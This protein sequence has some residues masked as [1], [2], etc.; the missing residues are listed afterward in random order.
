MCWRD[1]WKL[2]EVQK[3]ESNEQIFED[4]PSGGLYVLRNRTKGHEE[5]IF[6]YENGENRCSGD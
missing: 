2:L 4:M 3:A 5:R 1:G 6:T